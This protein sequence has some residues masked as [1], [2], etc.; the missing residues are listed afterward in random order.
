MLPYL[1]IKLYCNGYYI[2]PLQFRENEVLLQYMDE[3]HKGCTF[4]FKPISYEI[5]TCYGEASNNLQKIQADVR[6]MRNQMKERV[7]K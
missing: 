3:I 7:V 1:T 6:K 4:T 5:E 2:E